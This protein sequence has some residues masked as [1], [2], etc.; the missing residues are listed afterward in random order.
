MIA[1]RGPDGRILPTWASAEV[2]E[3]A[4]RFKRGETVPAIAAAM[5]RGVKS[6]R[7]QVQRLGLTRREYPVL[8]DTPPGWC[9]GASAYRKYWT[10]ERV[11]AALRAYALAHP[12]RL[13]RGTPAWNEITRGDPTLPTSGRI[14]QLYGALGNAWREVLGDLDARYRVPL[15]WV[16]WTPEEDAFIEQH[17][18]RLSMR[19]IAERLGRTESSLRQHAR[20]ALNIT[21]QL[22]REWWSPAEVAEHFGCPV[23][24]VYYLVWRGI[25]PARRDGRV[26]IDPRFLPGIASDYDRRSVADP[27]RLDAIERAL[28]EPH[29]RKRPLQLRGR[30]GP[31]YDGVITRGTPTR[32]AS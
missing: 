30:R 13:P 18:G 7:G 20:R 24:R 5:G 10:R 9:G 23:S 14:L 29:A 27:V 26:R 15:A 8:L 12:G 21:P 19:E 2:L 17:V 11:H 22:A 3:L 6:V 28:R 31:G 32:R 4:E 25:L 16:R 1:R